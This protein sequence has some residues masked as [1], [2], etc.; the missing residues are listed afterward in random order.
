VL[1]IRLRSNRCC[2][3]EPVPATQPKTGRPKGFRQQRPKKQR[4]TAS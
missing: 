1:L 2:S 4:C 3:F